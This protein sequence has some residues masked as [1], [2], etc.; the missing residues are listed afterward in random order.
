MTLP[1]TAADPFGLWDSV[2]EAPAPG[3]EAVSFGLPGLPE[4]VPTD[5]EQASPV[6]LVWKIRGPEDLAAR[7]LRMNQVSLGLST[8]QARL[9]EALKTLP[10]GQPPVQPSAD[11][12]RPTVSFDTGPVLTDGLTA[13][14]PDSPEERLLRSLQ[15]ANAPQEAVSFGLLDR[16]GS[17]R[18]PGG[19]DWQTLQTRPVSTV[20]QFVNAVNRQLFNFA[21]VDTEVEGRLLARTTINWAGDMTNVWLQQ[22]TP[23]Q[24]SLHYRSLALAIESRQVSLRAL[25]L[26]AS[27]AL[28]F[29]TPL[30]PARAMALAWQFLS[31]LLEL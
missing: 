8:A 1:P 20:E 13:I 22:A 10:P 24:A 15:A 6:G 4:P 9:S 28:T 17:D 23:E 12:F 2:I 14:P 18:L 30:G 21:W 7:A 25:A 3:K 27:L 31:D 16:S 26:V 5:G 19:P 11:R 29:P